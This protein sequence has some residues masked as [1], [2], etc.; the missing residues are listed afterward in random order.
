MISGKNMV[1]PKQQ[2]RLRRAALSTKRPFCV[3]LLS[4]NRN[5]SID[6]FPTLLTARFSGAILAVTGEICGKNSSPERV[7][8]RKNRAPET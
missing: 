6:F 7:R 4:R 8:L 5:G 3:Q 2:P 1:A